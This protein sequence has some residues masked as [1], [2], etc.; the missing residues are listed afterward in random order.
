MHTKLALSNVDLVRKFSQI[1]EKNIDSTFPTVY[2]W[3]FDWNREKLIKINPHKNKLEV[4]RMSIVS[5]S[6]IHAFPLIASRP[7]LSPSS[8]HAV[9]RLP[10]KVE[11]PTAIC[12]LR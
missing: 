11:D 4:L 2:T 9:L 5:L 3:I 7:C 8:I 6:Y 1:P 12:D 10:R